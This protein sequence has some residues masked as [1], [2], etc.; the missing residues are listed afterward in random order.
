MIF[1]YFL[2]SKYE[3]KTALRNLIA[4]VSPIGKI[5]E[6]HSDNGAEYMSKLFQK[7]LVDNGIK[8]TST[9]P[10]SPFHNGKSERNWRSLMEMA[11]C[12]RSDVN[13]SKKLLAICSEIR[14]VFK[15]SQLSTSH[16]KYCI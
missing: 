4:N 1:V 12:L 7:I 11:R 13:I 6:L 14:T 2:R 16:K 15:E 10:Y 8:Q 5:R 3:A 9:A